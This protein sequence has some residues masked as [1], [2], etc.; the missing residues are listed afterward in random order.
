MSSRFKFLTTGPGLL[1]F[2]KALLHIQTWS[3]QLKSLNKHFLA[4][5]CRS[6]ELCPDPLPARKKKHPIFI[7]GHLQ[8]LGKHRE[9][10]GA[11]ALFS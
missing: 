11:R 8:Q 10:I 5:I 1:I 9:E 2:G 6:L 7:F 4:T 3:P